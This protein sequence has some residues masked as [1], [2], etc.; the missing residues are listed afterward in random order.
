MPQT[1]WFNWYIANFV[2]IMKGS[3]S[4]DGVQQWS[5]GISTPVSLKGFD[6]SLDGFI[7]YWSDSWLF[8]FTPASTVNTIKN[9][10]QPIGRYKLEDGNGFWTAAKISKRYVVATTTGGDSSKV[11]KVFS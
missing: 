8:L 3:K 10:L 11:S 1:T 6:T 4:Q 5:L 2:R 9:V 7:I